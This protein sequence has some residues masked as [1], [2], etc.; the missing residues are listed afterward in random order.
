MKILKQE[1]KGNRVSLEIEVDYAALKTAIDKTFEEAIKEVEIPGF[2]KGKAP[3]PL[4]ESKINKE[5]VIDQASRNLIVDLYSEIINVAKLEPVDSPQVNITKLEEGKPFI[6]ALAVDVYPEVKLGKYK[7]VKVEKEKVS[8]AKEEVERSLSELQERFADY[9][10]IKD[11]EVRQGDLIE[12]DVKAEVSGQEVKVLTKREV[13]FLVGEG[14]I[15]KEFDKELLGLNLGEKKEIK[16]TLP[17]DFSVSEVAGKEVIFN[18]IIKKIVERKLPVLD[19]AFAKRFGSESLEKLK[20]EIKRKI[21]LHKQEEAE[22]KVKNLLIDKIAEEITV[23]LP[24]GLIR[25]EVDLMVDELRRSLEGSNLTLEDYLR[26]T[27][28]S[29]EEL[30]TEMKPAAGRRARAKVALHAVAK[31]EKILVTEEDFNAEIENLSKSMNQNP[32]EF[33]KTIGEAGTEYITDYLLRRKA[34]DLIL[35]KAKM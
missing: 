18:V 34:L 26:G 28:K 3:R 6:F 16:L 10:E 33:K 32:E 13:R 21:E 15:T 11:R 30:K 31:A 14:Q 24:E 29:I 2:R 23:E 8:V 35:S 12:A 4:L 20:D 9:T 5:A 1:R 22:T 7:G 27:R 17:K 25:R 19:D